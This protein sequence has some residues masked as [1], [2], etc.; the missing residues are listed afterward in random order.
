M[1]KVLVIE[2]ELDIAKLVQLH[3]QD[4]PCEVNLAFD[5]IVGLAEAEAKALKME[6]AD[7]LLAELQRGEVEQLRRS[8]QLVIPELRLRATSTAAVM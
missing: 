1:H 6:G 7:D 4:L 3:L 8:L 2:D 5:G